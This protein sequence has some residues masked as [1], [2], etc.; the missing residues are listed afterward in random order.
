M[1]IGIA[2]KDDGEKWREEGD[3]RIVDLALQAVYEGTGNGTWSFRKGQ[4]WNERGY[5][6]GKGGN[7]ANQGGKNSWQTGSGN[8]GSKGQKE[9]G[10]GELSVENKQNSSS[11][12]IIEA[13]DT[14][15]NVRVT[16]GSW[17]CG[18]CHDLRNVPTCQTRGRNITEEI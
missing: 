5:H 13:K 11:R 15:V 8:K 17:S 14:W 10:K 7:N 6:G 2:A 9:S 16:M 18:A 3:Q 12:K 4:S 1:E